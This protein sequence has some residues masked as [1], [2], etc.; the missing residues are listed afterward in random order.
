[1]MR[2]SR[3]Y[4]IVLTTAF[5]PAKCVR[6]G[7][8]VGRPNLAGRTENRKFVCKKCAALTHVPETIFGNT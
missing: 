2:E 5:R 3:K 6:C 1:M 8:F 7:K 4:S